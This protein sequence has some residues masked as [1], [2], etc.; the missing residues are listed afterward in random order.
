MIS[1]IDAIGSSTPTEQFPKQFFMQVQ[2]SSSISNLLKRTGYPLILQNCQRCYGPPPN[3]N[4]ARPP[5][6]S[7]VFVGKLPRDCFEDELVPVFEQVGMI[8]KIRIPIEDFNT[9][10]GYAF[11]NFSTTKE[12]SQCVKKL[13]NYEIRQGRTLGICMSVDNSRIFI[14]RIPKKVLKSNKISVLLSC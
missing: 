1:Q 12:A 8:Y 11:I 14:G 2:T 13:N 5:R 9:N 10:R 3:W 6:G 4:G 7:E